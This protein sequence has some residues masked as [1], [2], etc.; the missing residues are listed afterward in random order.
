MKRL[1]I[2][3]EMSLLGDVGG[4]TWIKTRNCG[5]G[6]T[7]LQIYFVHYILIIITNQKKNICIL[8]KQFG[9]SCHIVTAS[10]WLVFWLS[11]KNDLSLHRSTPL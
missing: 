9:G 11:K 4:P 3:G 1:H 10:L 6:G 5:Q 7:L 2:V 8:F